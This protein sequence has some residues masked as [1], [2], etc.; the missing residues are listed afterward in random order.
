MAAFPQTQV[1]TC[2]IHLL[3]HAMSFAIY[4]DRKA[5][6]AALKAVY[7]ANDAEAAE[8]AQSSKIRR[9]VR[10]RG[11]FPRDKAASN[12]IYLALN[13]TPSEWKRSVRE[14]HAVKSQFAIMF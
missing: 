1:Q 6:A 14:W 8:A 3:R 9:A 10:T 13:P 11:H 7:T 5:I 4:K 12:L 2:I